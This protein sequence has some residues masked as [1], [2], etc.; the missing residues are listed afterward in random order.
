MTIQNEFN[1]YQ[2]KGYPGQLARPQEPYMADL[3]E[4]GASQEI[5]PG[6]G[7]YLSSGKWIKPA[8]AA[9][10][11]LV[12]HFCAYEQNVIGTEIV[13]PAANHAVEIVYTDGTAIK[14]VALGT[15]FCVAGTDGIVPGDLAIFNRTTKRWDKHVPAVG[16]YRMAVF[17][18]GGKASNGSIVEVRN[19]G[20]QEVVPLA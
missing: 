16:E 12:T 8:D 4:V 2:Q 11:M 19:S 20:R 5:R 14:G 17:S 13:A 3:H 10:D 15:V 18:F 1:V 7:M 6:E 9:T